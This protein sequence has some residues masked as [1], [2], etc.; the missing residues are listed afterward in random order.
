VVTNVR[1][2]LRAGG[3]PDEVRASRVEAL[4][5]TPLLDLANP[6]PKDLDGHVTVDAA[7][8]PDAR[9]LGALVPPGLAF[10][11]ESGRARLSADVEIASSRATATG[12]IE[13]VL[14]DARVALGA[15]R[16]AG[17]F[18]MN[19]KIS[20]LE[21]DGVKLDLA[22]SGVTMRN[23][24]VIHASTPT[25]GWSGDLVFAQASLAFGPRT[26][27]DGGFRLEARDA[28]PLFAI[29]F[30]DDMPAILSGLTKMDHLSASGRVLADSDGVIF[31]DLDARGGDLRVHG[32]Y[33]RDHAARHGAFI[34][35]KGPFGVG[36]ELAAKVSI[37]LFGLRP[38]LEGERRIVERVRSDAD[39][40]RK[41][42]T[43]R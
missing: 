29:A 23:V 15:T 33:A 38:W 11:I 42:K 37:H 3:A 35:E 9:A 19:A 41:S 12:G 43:R 25:T 6:S 26:V 18:T 1:G 28:N 32:S 31:D 10:A 8:V 22:G 13:L 2:R 24:S 34:V 40:A 36:V 14:D 30:E 39:A 4:L 17:D 5:T 16:V 7:E 20:R 21:L 27:I